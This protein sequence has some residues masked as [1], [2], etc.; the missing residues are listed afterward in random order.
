MYTR[1]EEL[2]RRQ[3]LAQKKIDGSS[4]GRTFD[5]GS[6][7]GGSIPPPSAIFQCPHCEKNYKKK[8]YLNNHLRSHKNDISRVKNTD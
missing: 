6:N 3:A 7:D 4:N 5:F 1:G 2:R 8:M